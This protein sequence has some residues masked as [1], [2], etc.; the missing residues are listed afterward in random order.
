ME[1]PNDQA[2]VSIDAI[3]HAAIPERER[4]TETDKLDMERIGKIQ[5]L[6]VSQL[7]ST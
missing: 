4:G 7:Q 2:N 1:K 5:E 3:A 6:R